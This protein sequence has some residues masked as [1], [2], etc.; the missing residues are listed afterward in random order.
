MSLTS[1]TF[2]SG[3]IYLEQS[4]FSCTVEFAI[5]HGTPSTLKKSRISFWVLFCY[6]VFIRF[7]ARRRHMV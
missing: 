5:E 7:N 6:G 4:V 1:F 2:D 3:T